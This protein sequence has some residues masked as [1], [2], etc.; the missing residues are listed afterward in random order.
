MVSWCRRVAGGGQ[1]GKEEMP[2]RVFK[3]SKSYDE[4]VLQGRHV[5]HCADDRGWG[6]NL[7]LLHDIHDEV[8]YLKTP[9]HEWNGEKMPDRADW[10]L[11][12][13]GSSDFPHRSYL[14]CHV[15]GRTV[16]GDPQRDVSVMNA[17][18]ERS[19]WAS[20]VC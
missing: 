13:F 19:C 2:G 9:R 7:R 15:G 3:G 18:S 6:S 12:S 1:R 5:G 14:M 17:Q 10:G 8:F 16:G 4:A 20:W 11:L